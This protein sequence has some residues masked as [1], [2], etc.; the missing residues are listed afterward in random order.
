MSPALPWGNRRRRVLPVLLLLAPLGCGGAEGEGDRR[1]PGS[2]IREG[3]AEDELALLERSQT[4]RGIVVLAPEVRSFTPCGE[5]E[6]AWLRDLTGGE[7]ADAYADLAG[8]PYE[9]VY[10]E[11]VGALETGRPGTPRA[12]S[13]GFAALALTRSAFAPDGECPDPVD[14][15]HARGNEPFWSVEVGTLS[16]LYRSPEEPEGVVFLPAPI[17]PQGGTLR[18]TTREEEGSR[19]LELEL[20]EERCEDSMSGERFPMSARLRLEGREMEGC[21]FGG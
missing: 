17:R 11:L 1:P 9:P 16:L 8:I 14:G 3:S 18:L 7:I 4:F 10:M 2:S 13:W 20:R 15:I 21:A 6:S 12:F 19:T 5:D